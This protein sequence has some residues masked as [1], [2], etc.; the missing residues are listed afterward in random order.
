MAEDRLLILKFK[1]GNR[2]G[3]RRI[4]DKYKIDLLKLDVALIPD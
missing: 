3:L 2:E 1:L 4:Y